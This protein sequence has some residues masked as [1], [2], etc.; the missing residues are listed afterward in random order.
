MWSIA[1]LAGAA[2]SC[3]AP[4]DLGATAPRAKQAPAEVKE[5]RAQPIDSDIDAVTDM[6]DFSGFDKTWLRQN[7]LEPVTKRPFTMIPYASEVRGTEATRKTWETA[8]Y[9]NTYA[10]LVE[11]VAL[12]MELED[13]YNYL[14]AP[15]RPSSKDLRNGLQ[16]IPARLQ[17]DWD[18]GSQEELLSCRE[19]LKG[20]RRGEVKKHRFGVFDRTYCRYES[21]GRHVLLMRI[22]D[23]SD[24]K[25]FGICVSLSSE[26]ADMVANRNLDYFANYMN[27]L[28][29]EVLVDDPYA[30][31]RIRLSS[32]PEDE[33]IELRA[34]AAI[35]GDRV[36]IDSDENPAH[37]LSSLAGT[38]RRDRVVL[39]LPADLFFYDDVMTNEHVFSPGSPLVVPPM[40]FFD[41]FVGK[42]FDHSRPVEP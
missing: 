26:E 41:S 30:P 21:H 34:N 17:E 11:E 31:Y 25:F 8:G 16:L 33:T 20:N 13:I 6:I 22:G 23:G 28:L 3:N 10:N 40:H 5:E 19:I 12:D 1:L 4:K 7:A 38:V 36:F 9:E 39:V 2:V 27:D 32:K 29:H 15:W 37:Y 14:K 35:P 42:V 18:T 24:N